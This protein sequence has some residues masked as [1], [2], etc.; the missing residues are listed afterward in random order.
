MSLEKID[1]DQLQVGHYIRLD[2]AWADYP[3]LF[4]SF[5]I[6]TKKQIKII[7]D[8][9]LETITYDPSRSSVKVKKSKRTKDESRAHKTTVAEAKAKIREKAELAE[10]A[11][12]ESL[13]KLEV[14]DL[15]QRQE[16][17][18]EK[19]LRLE[20][21][22]K[23]R[24]SRNRCE[25]AFKE[26]VTG[27]NNLMDNMR[28]VP[29]ESVKQAEKLVG[30][31]VE[32]VMGTKSGS[33]Q[34]VDLKGQD[35]EEHLHIVNVT[36]LSLIVG[37]ELGLTDKEM[38]NLG[39]GAMLHDLGKM[40]IKDKIV[41]KK[42]TLSDTELKTFEL[43]PMYGAKLAKGLGNVTEEVLRIIAEHREL[44]DGTGYPNQ[45]DETKMSK[46]S[47][48]VSITTAYDD[49][50][51]SPRN[52]KMLTPYE[53]MSLMYSQ[54]KYDKNILSIFINRL[55][56]YPPGTLVKLSDGNLAGVT[57]VNHDDLLN[58]QVAIYN[59][60]IPKDEAE[61]IELSENEDLTIEESIRR[62]EASP[63][64]L[65]YLN[66][67]GTMNYFLDPAAAG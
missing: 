6:K 65:A 42:S 64:M 60:S 9:G 14:K 48:I 31:I 17:F 40:K 19:A 13:Q 32:T 46:L 47:K 58:P 10:K 5:K 41:R 25:K 57:G 38:K 1:V 12:K 28:A 18:Q 35:S 2:G 15:N 44:V 54:T 43:Y 26:S 33:M 30:N 27:V 55:G 67:A 50:C 62:N 61:I 53:A 36:M 66:L 20:L 29:E 49:L 56:V 24:I 8:M 59:E 34:L 7:R 22:Q 51:N 3:F 63:E 37:K 45:L 21:L 11:K 16:T 4:R 23:R 52:K 39:V